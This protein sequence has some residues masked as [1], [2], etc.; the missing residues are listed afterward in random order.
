MDDYYD[1]GTYSRP[2]TTRSPQA[3]L[4]FDR[5][6]VWCYGYNHDEAIRCFRKAIEHDRDCAMAYWGIAYASGPTTT[7]AGMPSSNRS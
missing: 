1:L 4:W 5:G 2:V 3:Q 6:L 7:S